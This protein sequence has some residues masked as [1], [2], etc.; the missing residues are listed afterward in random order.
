MWGVRCV[1]GQMSYCIICGRAA[2]VAGCRVSGRRGK[3]ARMGCHSTD[4]LPLCL[5]RSLC[6]S[7]PVMYR[8]SPTA[9]YVFGCRSSI[10]WSCRSS[11]GVA[12][13][14][15]M[16]WNRTGLIVLKHGGAGRS[17]Q[18]SRARDP[19]WNECRDQGERQA[20]PQHRQLSM[21]TLINTAWG[22]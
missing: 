17:C 7:P 3:T 4:R 14:V 15:V 19:M 22:P 13:L 6:S 12:G 21:W 9:V 16:V 20:S 10:T 8:P 18:S 1:R 5:G 11:G 2:G